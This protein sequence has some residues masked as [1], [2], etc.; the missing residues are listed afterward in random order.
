MTCNLFV[1]RGADP[2]GL[3]GGCHLIWGFVGAGGSGG[4][5]TRGRGRPCRRLRGRQPVD[6]GSTG[7]GAPSRAPGVALG[8]ASP[9]WGREPRI[10]VGGLP[11]PMTCCLPRWG[12]RPSCPVLGAG[13][14]PR[15]CWLAARRVGDGL[16]RLVR[17]GCYRAILPRGSCASSFASDAAVSKGSLGPG[18]GAGG[19]FARAAGGIRSTVP[20]LGRVRGQFCERSGVLK[21]IPSLCKRYNACKVWHRCKSG[22]VAVKTGPWSARAQ[23]PVGQVRSARWPRSPRR[24]DSGA[25]GPGAAAPAAPPAVPSRAPR[26]A[27]GQASPHWGRLIT[28]PNAQFPTPMARILPRCG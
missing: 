4:L 3:S 19:C 2:V 8:Q 25:L 28:C 10:G 11:A 7:A 1:M 9:H 13:P 6:W 23:A 14:C 18:E 15:S 16:H 21:G 12:R 26:A 5:P 27:L 24:A 17:V 22:G 20:A